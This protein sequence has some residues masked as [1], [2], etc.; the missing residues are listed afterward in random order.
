LFEFRRRSFFG[1]LDT[2]LQL[3]PSAKEINGH[4]SRT[5]PQLAGDVL[6]RHF[7]DE[8]HTDNGMLHL[9]Q[10]NH[11]AKGHGVLLRGGDKFI[12]GLSVCHQFAHGRVIG[13]VRLRVVMTA[14]AIARDV[15]SQNDQKARRIRLLPHQKP[16][17][18]QIQES[19]K[20]LLHA[21][22]GIIGANAFPPDRAD[23]AAPML[24]HEAG[25]PTMKRA[26]LV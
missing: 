8:A 22:E 17:L 6:S 24:M 21:I 13:D 1:A 7:I 19:Q 9:A 12:R 10:C 15:P 16:C 11:A 5:D 4:V 2:P 3:P 18:R 20:G 14:A 25:D 23:Q 26:V